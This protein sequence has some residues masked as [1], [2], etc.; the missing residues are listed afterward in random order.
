MKW[1]KN[2]P[3]ACIVYNYLAKQLWS[4]APLRA[5][6]DNKI[7]IISS[8]LALYS[9]SKQKIG[10]FQFDFDKSPAEDQTYQEASSVGGE[11]KQICPHA[12]KFSIFFCVFNF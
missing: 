5:Y 2:Y 11:S 3:I 6:F 1:R 12:V 4:S 7:K 8:L 10:K 9:K